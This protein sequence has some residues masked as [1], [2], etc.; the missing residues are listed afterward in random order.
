MSK[1][2]LETNLTKVE[3]PEEEPVKRN[4]VFSGKRNGDTLGHEHLDSVIMSIDGG[5]TILIDNYTI[6]INYPKVVPGYY[7]GLDFG[8][9]QDITIGDDVI[10]D[11]M[12]RIHRK[13]NFGG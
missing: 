13:I 3:E 9:K 11:R 12:G 2:K 8:T 5:W 7:S 1:K 6:I 10:I 4:I